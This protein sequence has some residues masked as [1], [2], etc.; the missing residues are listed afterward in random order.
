M[1]QTNLPLY[2]LCILCASFILFKCR[3]SYGYAVPAPDPIVA[4]DDYFQLRKP[5]KVIEGGKINA[6][7]AK[8]L[9]YTP[10]GVTSSLPLAG[11]VSGAAGIAGLAYYQRT[12]VDPVYAAASAVASAADHIFVPA[13]QAFR[14][15]FVSPESFPSAAA[16]Y[17]GVEGSVGISVGDLV[18]FAANDLTGRFDN[19][20]AAITSVSGINYNPSEAPQLGESFVTKAGENRVVNFLNASI[21]RIM[22]QSWNE[23]PYATFIQGYPGQILYDHTSGLIFIKTSNSPHLYNGSWY[24]PVVAYTSIP[25]ATVNPFGYPYT[26][27]VD[28]PSLKPVL[29]NASPAVA[30]EVE[31]AIQEAPDAQ[32]GVSSDPAPSSAPAQV[33]P[34]I[35][36]QQLQNFYAQ[37]ASSVV[38]TFQCRIQA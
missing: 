8:P 5:L 22:T 7:T 36:Q 30:D 31:L 1:K 23:S 16:Q 17:V 21:V 33:Q 35:N 3:A 11:L 25:S 32:K 9:Y 14:D 20:K 2:L 6:Q 18:T 15:T 24:Y 38:S 37:N 27:V 28:Y 13:Y 19:L 12:G 4:A 10:P 26:D 29:E 34:A